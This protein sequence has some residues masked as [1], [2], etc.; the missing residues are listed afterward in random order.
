[1]KGRSAEVLRLV[2]L[3]QLFSQCTGGSF[4]DIAEVSN[5]KKKKTYGGTEMLS[6]GEFGNRRGNSAKE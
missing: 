5:G 6:K 3:S 2:L 4:A 1:M